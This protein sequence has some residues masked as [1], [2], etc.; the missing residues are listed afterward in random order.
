MTLT[1]PVFVCVCA[2]AFLLMLNLSA[3]G[4][5]IWDDDAQAYVEVVQNEAANKLLAPPQTDQ[6]ELLWDDIHDGDGDDLF[7]NYSE[8]YN[9]MVSL[10][11]N[12][13]QV[14]TGTL[15][16]TLLAAYDVLVLIDEEN[17]Y[18][19]AEITDV[20]NWIAGGGKLLMIGENFNAFNAASNNTMIAPYNM[21]FYAPAAF[22][23][24]VNNFATHPITT[25]LTNV[26]WA[27]GS[28]QSY[29]APA[30]GI[31]WDSM[32]Q[33][34]ITTNEDGVVVVVFNDSNMMQ[35]T[36][37][38][39]DDNYACMTNILNFLAAGAGPYNMNVELTYVSGSPVPASGGNVYFEVFVESL[40]PMPIDFDGWLAVEMPG[41]P[42]PETVALR[43]F[44]NFLPSWTI[45]RPDMYFPVPGTW[46]AGGY[47]F[48]GRVGT[49]P[50]DVWDESA[51]QFSKLSS[52]D[53]QAT[54]AP[55]IA[56]EMP[57]PF[58]IIDKGQTAQ[59]LQYG[60]LNCY[61]NPFNPSTVI[62]YQVSELTEVN[63]AVY[64]VAGREVATLV[65]GYRTAGI[66]EV[67]FDASG[68]PSGVYFA[69]LT[70]GEV[71]QTHKLL[72]VK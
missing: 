5:V 27:A 68:L 46:P 39:N 9:L 26:T 53:G 4:E 55:F 63:L 7:G 38:F 60:L 41:V 35:N 49:H 10:G 31:G 64:D 59:V 42:T 37:I 24:G 52:G 70:A 32:M 44:T 21:Q 71:Q 2:A 72:L 47:V 56:A 45:N 8:C 20:Q 29:S 18:D 16:S 17:A 54:G 50:N 1:R 19:P 23:T 58:A 57:D 11:Y 22:T 12:A 67:T 25:G 36:Y 33:Y 62:A 40:E 69:S 61:P 3:W 48:W 51:F 34:G 65:N 14:Q 13:T 30:E 66:H 15:N 28:A 6:T 43:S